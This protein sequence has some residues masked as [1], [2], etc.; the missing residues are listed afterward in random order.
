MVTYEQ[1]KL[2]LYQNTN[3]A[4]TIIG[5]EGDRPVTIKLSVSD[6]MLTAEFMGANVLLI[7]DVGKG[8][9]QLAKDILN[10]H[11]NGS[12][13]DG[14]G[15]FM[16]ARK[17]TNV[18]DLFEY[19]QADTSEG[20]FDSRTARM[21][22]VNRTSRLIHIVDELN[23]APP[24]TQSD[25]L[26]LAEGTYSLKGDI[27]ELGRDGYSVF[28]GAVNLNKNGDEEFSGTFKIDRAL[29]S[30]SHLTLDLD[31]PSFSPTEED[32]AILEER[33]YTSPKV[34]SYTLSDLTD[35]I[36]EQNRKIKE[37]SRQPSLE[38][39]IFRYLIGRS[40]GFC[41]KDVLNDKQGMFPDGCESCDDPKFCKEVRAVSERT[42]QTLM[43][44]PHALAIVAELKHGSSLDF[45]MFDLLLESYK[46]TSFHGNLNSRM[47]HDNYHGRSQAMMDHVVSELRII[48][49]SIKPFV[50]GDYLESEV[51]EYN[52]GGK[53]VV[54]LPQI[55]PNLRN[56]KIPFRTLNLKEVLSAKGLGTNWIEQLKRK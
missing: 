16:K 55:V 48:L 24:T 14:K 18:P 4:S 20:K 29:L 40:F 33:G 44:L 6:I 56:R 7:S 30:R 39:K 25:F 52:Q 9:T 11:Y 2:P 1:F 15:N 10:S 51:I 3:A 27:L 34:K 53:K 47:I 46:F 8:K 49:D 28:I 31:H 41:S 13:P 17:D 19:I 23:R 45:N 21:L 26:D 38:R 37:M 32:E 22:N 5:Y 43:G 42:Q 36:L 12:G 54:T 50:N 35:F